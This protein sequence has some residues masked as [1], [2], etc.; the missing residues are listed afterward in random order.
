MNDQHDNAQTDAEMLQK[1]HPL[2]MPRKATEKQLKY[3]RDLAGKQD[4]EDKVSTL[5]PAWQEL[6]HSAAQGNDNIAMPD[7]SK[8]I[9][10]LKGCPVKQ[11]TSLKDNQPGIP[12]QAA[13]QPVED[14]IYHKGNKFYKVYWNRENNRLLAKEIVLIRDAYEAEDGTVVP[15]VSELRYVGQANRFV[16]AS[17]KYNPTLEEAIAFGP[18]YGRCSQCFRNLNDEVSVELGI[19][20]V[21]GARDFG[22]AF[23]VMHKMAEAKLNNKKEESILDKMTAEELEAHIAQLRALNVL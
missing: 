1:L 5:P 22:E 11:T 16:N 2:R 19:G 18:K 12:A 15:A 23:K 13:N 9:D 8:F 14:G 7:I 6:F 17:D 21:C 3:F 4:W 20:P 10:L